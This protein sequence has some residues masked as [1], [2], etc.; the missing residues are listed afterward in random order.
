MLPP[1]TKDVCREIEKTMDRRKKAKRGGCWECGRE[2]G[3]HPHLFK[4][5]GRESLICFAPA[6][7]TAC[8]SHDFN[9]WHPSHYPK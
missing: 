4:G 1:S 6:L 5:D 7:I 3:I 9:A 2:M 8:G